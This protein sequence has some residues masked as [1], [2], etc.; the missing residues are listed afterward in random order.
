MG[1]DC[2]A[3][4]TPDAEEIALFN[5]LGIIGSNLYGEPQLVIT[6]EGIELSELVPGLRYDIEEST[7]LDQWSLAESITASSE[8]QTWLPPVTSSSSVIARFYRLRFWP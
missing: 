2:D 1:Q 6:S 5:S 8:S 7:N 4:G 3:D